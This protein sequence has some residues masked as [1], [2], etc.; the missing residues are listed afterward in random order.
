MSEKLKDIELRSEEVQEVLSAVPHWMIR[1]GS[2]LFLVLL[3]MVLALSWFIK[4]PDIIASEAIITTEIP[5]QKEYARITGNLDTLFVVDNESVSK[6][7]P[8]S[9]LE[10]SASHSDVFFLKS[11]IDT[12]SLKNNQFSFPIT[13]IPILFLGEVDASYALFENSYIQYQ[14]NKDL[15]PFKNEATSNRFIISELRR[16]LTNLEN[17]KEINASELRFRESDLDRFKSLHEKGVIAT[18]EYETKQLEYLQAERN[19]KNMDASISQLRESIAGA[20]S[21]L[22]SKQINS[23]RE[24]MVLL[25]GVIQSFNQLKKSIEDWEMKYVLESRINGN[26]TFLNFWNENQTVNQGDLV[27]TIIPSENSA[28]VA[29]LKTPTQN[30]GKIKKGQRV[31]IKL[32]NYPDTEFGVLTGTVDKISL[33]ADEEGFYRIDVKL[34]NDLLTS[35]NKK[36]NFRQEM[37]GVAEVVTEDLRLI[38][39]FFYQ[40]RNILKRN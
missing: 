39:R 8:L 11:I 10:N 17:Q 40:L 20:S 26:V 7:Q 37:R 36:I 12:V 4:Y 3:L 23:T 35:Y 38:E 28:Y 1:W 15:Q 13:D 31:N 25:K 5:P 30:S 34:P 21:N 32:E 14:L 22:K 18:S 27:F 24:E 16:R 29:K 33:I 9:V 19:Y 2:L 6:G